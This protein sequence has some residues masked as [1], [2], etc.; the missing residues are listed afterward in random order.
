MAERDDIRVLFTAHSLPAAVLDEGD[1]YESQL[2]ET[3]RMVADVLGLPAETWQLCYQSAGRRPGPWLGPDVRE[4]IVGLAEA[5][6]KRILVAPIGFVAD[7]LETLYDLDIE[8]RELAE[9][10]GVHLER[11]ASLNTAPAFIAAL[12]SVVQQATRE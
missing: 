11:S 5:G 4:T 9:R 12:A 8:C 10:R 6:H 7:H 1:P 2:R 3:A